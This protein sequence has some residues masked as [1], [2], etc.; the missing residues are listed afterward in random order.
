MRPL[1]LLLVLT[2]VPFLASCSPQPKELIVGKWEPTSE[3]DKGDTLE[4]HPDGTLTR[5]LG[6]MTIKAAYKFTAEE[7]V[8]LELKFSGLPKPRMEKWKVKVTKEQLTT[9][10]S[11]NK[12]EQFKR[13][14]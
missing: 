13:V 5:K 7:E 4:F 10:D 1:A 14:K 2:V 12:A 3:K 9:T 6:P 11:E 8:E